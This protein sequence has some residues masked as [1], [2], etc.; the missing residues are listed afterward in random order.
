[1]R[2]KKIL[3]AGFAIILAAFAIIQFIP[4]AP[5]V[6]PAQLPPADR[7]AH[8]LLNFEAISNFRDLGGY[9][10]ENGQQVKWGVLY[11]SATLAESTPGDL[12]NLSRL[13]LSTVI[14]FRSQAEKE[15]EPNR[16]P[17]PPGFRL[18]EIP[19][20]DDGNKALVGEVMARIESGDFDG[21]DPD[22]AMIAAN[23]QFVVEFT[24]QFRQFIDTV[25][26]ANGAPVLWHCSAGKDRTGFAT[27]ILLRIL[28]VPEDVVMGDY[29]ASKQPALEARRGQ[30][31]LLRLFKGEEAAD[32]L[33]VMMGVEPAWLA[34]AFE[35][36]DKRWGGFDD[37]VR[38]GLQLDQQDIA[39]LRQA[40]LD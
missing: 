33:S 2:K 18:V 34:A 5:L 20:L 30:L 38:D 3:W 21:F 26:E 9:P 24:P 1:L 23:R 31:L 22:Q 37:Y 12:Q 35:E 39:R 17:D 27:A 16:L 36:V 40:L 8:R 32:K 29:L 14:D 28:G 11:R 4:A 25:L 19:T 6:V 15:E 7:E 10:T 13:Q